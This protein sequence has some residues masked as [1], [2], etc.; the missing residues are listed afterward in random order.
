MSKE[1][2]VE[3]CG[4]DGGLILYLPGDDPRYLSPPE[5][6]ELLHAIAGLLGYELTEID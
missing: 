4:T 6:T 3:A 2:E 5:A 1:V